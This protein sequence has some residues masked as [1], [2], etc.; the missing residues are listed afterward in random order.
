MLVEN[1]DEQATK[2]QFQQSQSLV[3]S[4]NLTNAIEQTP[5]RRDQNNTERSIGITSDDGLL[6][7][8]SGISNSARGD[9]K[10]LLTGNARKLKKSTFVMNSQKHSPNKEPL[11]NDNLDYSDNSSLDAKPEIDSEQKQKGKLM[12]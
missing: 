6:R 8:N 3:P 10:G 4:L 11:A 5:S 2:H 9:N 7:Q 1:N 12:D